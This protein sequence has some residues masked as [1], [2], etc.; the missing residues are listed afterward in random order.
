MTSRSIPST[1]PR[2]SLTYD[3]ETVFGLS[4][5]AQGTHQQRVQTSRPSRESPPNAK[6]HQSS[7]TCRPLCS[8]IIMRVVSP[9]SFFLMYCLAASIVENAER[10]SLH[11]SDTTSSLWIL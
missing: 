11:D 7:A 8:I 2:S 5:C 1:R 4:V 9:L 6:P 3:L 10:R